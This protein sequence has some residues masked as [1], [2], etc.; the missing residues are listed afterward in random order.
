MDARGEADEGRG[1]RLQVVR[2][3]GV[4]QVQRIERRARRAEGRRGRRLP[5]LHARALGGEGHE[6]HLGWNQG[7]GEGDDCGQCQGVGK[8][9][10]RSTSERG[11]PRHAGSNRWSAIAKRSVNC[12]CSK[13][14]GSPTFQPRPTR[15]PGQSKASERS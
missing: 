11:P 1:R 8:K 7:K 10:T 5:L 13:A 3:A 4:G 9:A 12:P 14:G 6:Q 15:T 2:V